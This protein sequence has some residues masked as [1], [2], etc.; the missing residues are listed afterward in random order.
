MAGL[1]KRGSA[2]TDGMVSGAELHGSPAE[3]SDEARVSVSFEDEP[4]ACKP[5]EGQPH[6]LL[7]PMASAA[8]GGGPVRGQ[9]AE[10]DEVALM[11][12]PE[13]LVALVLAPAPLGSADALIVSGARRLGGCVGHGH[14]LRF[15][16]RSAPSMPKESVIAMRAMERAA[17]GDSLAGSDSDVGEMRASGTCSTL[18]FMHSNR[19]PGGAQFGV[20]Y[21]ADEL[22]RCC[23]GIR[24]LRACEGDGRTGTLRIQSLGLWGAGGFSGA[25]PGLRLLLAWVAAGL[26]DA[27]LQIALPCKSSDPD[28]RYFHAG[29][30]NILVNMR[31]AVDFRRVL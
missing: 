30:V 2:G 14:R 6:A 28:A 3:L 25:Q 7:V 24:A 4:K 20:S 26:A 13:A 29:T 31:V 21:L 16:A 8:L 15:V 23:L 19:C 22:T 17:A 5:E 11:D 10:M 1:A 27:R 18:L 9:S 12:H